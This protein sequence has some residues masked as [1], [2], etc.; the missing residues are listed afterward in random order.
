MHYDL[1]TC[2]L[3][4][5][6]KVYIYRYIYISIYI[7]LR[8]KSLRGTIWIHTPWN[9]RRLFFFLF[10]LL[11]LFYSSRVPD[12][13]SIHP[14]VLCTPKKENRILVFPSLSETFLRLSTSR[15]S[16]ESYFSLVVPSL[17]LCFHNL[18]FPLPSPMFGV[19]RI[20]LEVVM[21]GRTA[22]GR[23]TSP[24]DKEE[25]WT[26]TAATDLFSYHPLQN[27]TPRSSCFK[28]I[29]VEN[30]SRYFKGNMNPLVSWTFLL[31]SPSPIYK[32][33]RKYKWKTVPFGS[34]KEKAPCHHC[35]ASHT[36]ILLVGKGNHRES[37]QGKG[38]QR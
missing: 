14:R 12:N 20:T 34:N 23:A 36:Q 17:D 6:V 15:W 1:T 26:M 10:F 13:Q 24:G 3:R 22:R 28:Q 35:A 2:T 9:L 5:V 16:G 37:R 7:G 18:P 33:S 30:N 32:A 19:P 29:I 25:V 27:K 38:G 8:T 21:C 31:I 11:S 4:K